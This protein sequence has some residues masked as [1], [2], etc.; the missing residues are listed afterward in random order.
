MSALSFWHVAAVVVVLLLFFAHRHIPL[1]LGWLGGA[2]ARFR[3]RLKGRRHFRASSG[4]I[5]FE[6]RND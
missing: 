2:I 6:R 3:H 5:P 1:A 4:Q